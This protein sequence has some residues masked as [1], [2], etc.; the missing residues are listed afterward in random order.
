[1][2]KNNCR[3]HFGNANSMVSCLSICFYIFFHSLCYPN[4]LKLNT[5]KHFNKTPNT[6]PKTLHTTSLGVTPHFEGA[7][8]EWEVE[9]GEPGGIGFSVLLFVF[10]LVW[11][12]DCVPGLALQ[13][14]YGLP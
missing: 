11:I 1:M 9:T 10:S 3:Y 2:L 4:P 12:A 5:T 6:Q 14:G 7:V 8:A 13:A